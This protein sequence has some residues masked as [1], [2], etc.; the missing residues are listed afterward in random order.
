MNNKSVLISRIYPGAAAELLKKANFSVTIWE[1]SRPMTQ[2]ELIARAKFHDALFCNMT[3]K[4]DR[5]FLNECSHLRII[6]QFGVGYDNVD[7]K[8]ATR[9]GIPVGY[10]PGAMSDATADIAFGLMI[11]ATRKMFF[12]NRKILNGNWDILSPSE[13][14][15]MELKYKTLGVY[16]LGRIGIKMAERCKSAY[17]MNILYHNRT[18]NL[19]AE[20]ELQAE[21]V[22]FKNLLI[23]SDVISVHSSLND[24][25]EGVFNKYAF[26]LM[27]PTSVFINTSRGSIHNEQDLIVALNKGIIW[28]AGLDVTNP[29][30]MLP[31]NPLLR[32]ENVAI[33]PHIGSATIEAREEM[34]K[35]A[36]VNIIEY[37]KNGRVP[38][39]VNPES[40]KK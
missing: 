36:A 1:E 26:E 34:A 2:N 8:E 21:Y 6:S 12:L 18:R 32:M 10:T 5:T 27:K 38:Y 20:K 11:A 23:R 7:I 33:L 40:L 14:L 16:G 17:R 30:P 22:D 24:Q 35:L 39:I 4:I 9:L 25:T 19:L 28:G 37:Y 3:D 15:G 13:H 29:E 31:D